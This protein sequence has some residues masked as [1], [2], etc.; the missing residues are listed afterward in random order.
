MATIDELTSVFHKV[1]EDETIILTP[2][3]TANDVEG[4]DS[5][6]HI[7]LILSIENQFKIKF[8]QKEILLLKNVGDLLNI[9]ENKSKA[10][11]LQR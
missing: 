11:N 1:F 6:S 3:T 7:I 10:N 9:I 8:S 2:E 4:W 5:L